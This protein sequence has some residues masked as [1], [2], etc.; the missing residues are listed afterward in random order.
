MKEAKTFTSGRNEDLQHASEA[1]TNNT[2]KEGNIWENRGHRM[3]NLYKD[4]KRTTLKQPGEDHVEAHLPDSDGR[5]WY[6]R[7]QP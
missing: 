4:D 7:R 1:V 3:G 5:P 6:K 2:K